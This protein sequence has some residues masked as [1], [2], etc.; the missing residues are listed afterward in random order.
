M[1]AR[2]GNRFDDR[3]PFDGFQILQLGLERGMSRAGHRYL[4]HPTGSVFL[5][6]GKLPGLKSGFG[7]L[8]PASGRVTFAIGQGAMWRNHAKPEHH[9]GFGVYNVVS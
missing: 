9:S 2:L 8:H 6:C 7:A 3:G 5:I 4:F 1:F